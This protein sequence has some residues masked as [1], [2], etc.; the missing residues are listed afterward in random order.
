[1]QGS[2]DLEAHGL[3]DTGRVREHNEDAFWAD[4]ARGLFVVADGMGGHL[5]GRTAS[6]LAVDT[7]RGDLVP[8]AD[9]AE[10]T[11]EAL[12]AA[13][14]ERLR[15]A[16]RVIYEASR[17]DA[18]LRGMGTTCTC[19][20]APD[21]QAA[22]AH[23]GDSRCYLCRDGRLMQLTDDHSLVNEHLRAGRMSPEE[24]RRSRLKNVITRSVGFE[25]DVQVDTLALPLEA[26]DRL[27]LCSDGLT[28]LVADAAIAGL[29]TRLPVAEVPAGLVA[30]ANARGGDDNITAVVVAVSARPAAGAL[31]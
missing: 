6:R 20:W 24:A 21:G 11:A 10:A 22:I 28:N 19:L 31:G 13:L 14:A 15:R 18:G 12:M 7:L 3:T 29:L 16:C 2:L 30:E 5:G 4:A 17:D 27:L 25:A 1:M 9:A 23:V 26:G 8:P